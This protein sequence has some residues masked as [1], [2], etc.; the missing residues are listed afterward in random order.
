MIPIIFKD[1][2][3][4]SNANGAWFMYIP[5]EIAESLPSKIVNIEYDGE[6]VRL[7]PVVRDSPSPIKSR[8]R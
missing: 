3:I 6:V 2:K 7:V 5:K 8:G 4:G 1:R